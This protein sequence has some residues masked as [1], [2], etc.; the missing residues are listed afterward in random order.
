MIDRASSLNRRPYLNAPKMKSK[1]D[2]MSSVA[3]TIKIGTNGGDGVAV[4]LNGH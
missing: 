4:H 3:T 2:D 1:A